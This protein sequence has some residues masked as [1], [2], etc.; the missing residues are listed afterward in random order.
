MTKWIISVGGI[1]GALAAIFGL[2]VT[3]GGPTIA[4]GTDIKRLDRQQAETAT[5]VYSTKL[6]SLIIIAPPANT[7]AHQAWQEELARAR[8]QLKRAEDR[9]IE[10]SK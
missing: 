10:L 5:E 1:A 6:R 2:W 8:D 3:I 9:K 7:A 4:T